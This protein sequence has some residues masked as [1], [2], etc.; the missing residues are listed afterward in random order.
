MYRER[1]LAIWR[2]VYETCGVTTFVRLIVEALDSFKPVPRVDWPT[3][4]CNFGA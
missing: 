4:V 3:R 1:D 2:S